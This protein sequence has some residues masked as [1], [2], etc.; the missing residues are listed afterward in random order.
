MNDDELILII[1]PTAAVQLQQFLKRCRGEKA[2]RSTVL[3]SLFSGRASWWAEEEE[4]RRRR[5]KREEELGGRVLKRKWS[6]EGTREGKKK[7]THANKAA[8]AGARKARPDSSCA[9]QETTRAPLRSPA[10]EHPGCRVGLGYFVQRS[11]RL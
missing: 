7:A 1:I 5:E 10:A 9:T 8:A 2:A 3:C 11:V 4:G 6:R